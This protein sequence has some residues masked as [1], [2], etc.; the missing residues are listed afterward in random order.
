MLAGNSLKIHYNLSQVLHTVT[1]MQGNSIASLEWVCW[2][3]RKRK[4]ERAR[5]VGGGGGCVWLNE[6]GGAR[7]GTVSA[8]VFSVI[9]L[10]HSKAARHSA[11]E[12]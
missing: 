3:E 2:R 7:G 9:L 8:F 10:L 6:R 4:R 5:R 12:E 11:G 1:L